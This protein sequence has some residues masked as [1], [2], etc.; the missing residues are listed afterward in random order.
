MK[1][2]S[3]YLILLLFCV[4][5]GFSVFDYI[6]KKKM[7]IVKQKELIK[8]YDK[9]IAELSPKVELKVKK[10]LDDLKTTK[11]EIKLDNG[12]LLTKFKFLNG[13]YAG[14]NETYP[15]SG[16]LDFHNN[17]LFVI[18][19]RGILAYTDSY[20][21]MSSF[22]QIE[23][24]IGDFINLK[25]FNKM[26]W[27]SIKDL[28]IKDNKI[29]VSYTEEIEE[30]CWNT[31]IIYSEIDYREINFQKLF[32]PSEC[33]HS[34]KNQDKEFNAHQSG[35]KIDFYNNDEIFF[36]IGDYRS[37]S[38]AQNKNSINGKIIKLNINSKSY[39]TISIG[40]RNP[41]GLFYDEENNFILESE[42]GPD[43]G[44]EI[45]LIHLNKNEIPNFGWAIASYGEHYGGKK[46]SNKLKYQKYP[47]L[48]PHDDNKFIEP[49]KY[50]VPSI[51]TSEIV[52]IKSNSYVL[53]S[54]KDKA[55]YFFKLNN[56]NKLENFS[57]IKVT[58]RVRDII[59][60]DKKLFLFLEN[61]ASIGIIEL[62]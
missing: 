54:L 8:Q 18:S 31:S 24:N 9:I 49:I 41:Q 62:D 47:L 32:S 20:D 30:D 1:K 33:V 52:G 40:H 51:G 35:G 42:H 12:L 3:L 53:S 34:K 60:K 22:K 26:K 46:D 25:Q 44:D 38:L 5:A 13:F 21:D 7:E 23:N 6:S 61:T 36:T 55:I 4:Y 15:G 59:Y 10:S 45:N 19:A 29:F 57:R 17:N 2:N 39:E 56:S 27:F 58:E 37:R 11:K 43:G 48:K 16:Y 28:K 14:I 50:F